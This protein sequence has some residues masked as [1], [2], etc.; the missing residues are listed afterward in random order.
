PAFVRTGRVTNLKGK[1]RRNAFGLVDQ[2]GFL[3]RDGANADLHEREAVF[4]DARHHTGMTVRISLVGLP[5]ISVRVDLHDAEVR[6]RFGVGANGSE[7]TRMLACQ[8][9]V[10]A[11][12][13]DVRLDECLDGLDGVAVHLPTQ[14]ERFAS[15]DAAPLTVWFEA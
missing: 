4:D 12:G 5:Q 15:R 3:R 6:P 13:I 9:D 2:R 14:V 10:E 8:R 1:K 7:R 11:F